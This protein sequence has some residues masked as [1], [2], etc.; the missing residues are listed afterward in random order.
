[1]GETKCQHQFHQ[2]FGQKQLVRRLEVR[3]TIVKDRKVPRQPI[4]WH[5]Y[6]IQGLV[7]LLEHLRTPQWTVQ[8]YILRYNVGKKNNELK[9]TYVY[10]HVLQVVS[11]IRGILLLDLFVINAHELTIFKVFL[12]DLQATGLCTKQK[13]M[14]KDIYI[15]VLA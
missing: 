6:P 1:M 7:Y 14:Y 15:S 2:D 4:S 10:S 5:R 11:T 3:V 13:C 12:C 9:D 8:V